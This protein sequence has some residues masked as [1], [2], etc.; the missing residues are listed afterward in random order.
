MTIAVGLRE[1]PMEVVRFTAYLFMDRAD[2]LIALEGKRR[3]RVTLRL[4]AAVAGKRLALEKAA[5]LK[6]LEAQRFQWDVLRKNRSIQEFIVRQALQQPP[7]AAPA[8]ESGNSDLELSQEEERELDR[9]IAEVEETLAKEAKGRAGK[10]K[11]PLGIRKTWEEAHG[12]A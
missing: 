6:E 7:A 5:F 3:A 9:L 4:R 10:K 1:F 8:P 2:P 12:R 11:D